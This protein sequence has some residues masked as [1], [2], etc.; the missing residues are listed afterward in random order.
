MSKVITISDDAYEFVMSTAH[1]LETQNNR[2]TDTPIFR[3]YETQKVERREGC[4]DHVERLDYEGAE[5]HYCQDCKGILESTDY[6]YDQLPDVFSDACDCRY[7]DGATWTF[8]K[9]LLPASGGYDGVAFLTE[10]AAEEYRESNHYHFTGGGVVYAESAFRNHELKT[11]IAAIK[12]IA[13]PE[14]R[15]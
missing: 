2:H 14:V 9:E 4:G 5:E 10:K 13:N 11:L 12:E 8:D 1:E 3:I 6:D 15:S 7:S